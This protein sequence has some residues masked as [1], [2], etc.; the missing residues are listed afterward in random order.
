MAGT[1]RETRR[2]DAAIALDLVNI[3]AGQLPPADSNGVH[4]PKIRVRLAS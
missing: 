3:R 1:P 2:A 4:Y